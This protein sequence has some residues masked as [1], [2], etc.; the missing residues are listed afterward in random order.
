MIFE[1]ALSSFKEVLLKAFSRVRWY[2]ENTLEDYHA[3]VVYCL[4]SGSPPANLYLHV[5]I[6]GTLLS[7]KLH[8]GFEEVWQLELVDEEYLIKEVF[9]DV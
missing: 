8:K 4:K 2:H 6:K 7:D 9:K 5:S 1:K 3:F